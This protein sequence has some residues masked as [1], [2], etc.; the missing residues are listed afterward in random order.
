M[1]LIKHQ[2]NATIGEAEPLR[3][4]E[5]DSFVHFSFT[6]IPSLMERS[7][8]EATEK[9][10]RLSMH[11][12]QESL[13]NSI[14]K[15]EKADKEILEKI[16]KEIIMMNSTERE[17]EKDGEKRELLGEAGKWTWKSKRAKKK[18]SYIGKGREKH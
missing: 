10:K 17:R 14:L 13:K 6:N 4:R 1:V 3:L 2:L 8:K 9:Q 16:E 7:L 5:D 12:S 15:E 11:I 18:G